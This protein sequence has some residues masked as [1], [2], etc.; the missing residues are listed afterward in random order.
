MQVKIKN[1]KVTSLQG[2]IA[3]KNNNTVCLILSQTNVTLD[4]PVEKKEIEQIEGFVKQFGNL[5][6][7]K[8]GKVK[9]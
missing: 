4:I 1:T 8:L 5:R 6:L 9:I 7:N 3:C 2:K